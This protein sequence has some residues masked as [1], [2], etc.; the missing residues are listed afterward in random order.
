M[1]RLLRTFVCGALPA[2]CAAAPLH[3]QSYHVAR[4]FT[5]GGD[6]GWDYV[7]LDTAGQRLFVARQT[8]VMVIDPATGKLLAE[9]PPNRAHGVA[10]SYGTGK[11]RRPEATAA[12]WCS[13]SRRCGSSAARPPRSTRTRCCTTRPRDT[14]SRSTAMPDR[15]ASSTRRAARTSGRFPWAANQNSASRPET[16][17]YSRISRTRARSW[18][19]TRPR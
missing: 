6:G 4:T 12:S 11:P 16:A 19:S 14:F 18:K 9:I 3:A 17:S 8:R 1:L 7:A 10:F 13:T 15:R 2:L 5:L